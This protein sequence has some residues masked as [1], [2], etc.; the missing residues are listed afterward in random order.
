MTSLCDKFKPKKIT[1]IIG[2]KKQVNEIIKWLN[3]KNKKN[4]KEKALLIHGKPGI[5]KSSS[6]DVII[7]ELKL[8][9]IE[10]NASDKR[11]ASSID[12]L[13]PMVKCKP[14]FGMGKRVLVMDEV[15]GMSSG[16]RGGVAKLKSLI[17]ISKVPIICIANDLSGT[18]LTPIKSLSKKIEFFPPDPQ[19]ITNHVYRLVSQ[20]KGYEKLTKKKVERVV[21]SAMGDIRSIFNTIQLQLK[22]S[23]KDEIQDMSMADVV[24]HYVNDKEL[25]PE[26]RRSLFFTDCTL[27]PCYIHHMYP[28]FVTSLKDITNIADNLS[29]CDVMETEIRSN[30]NWQFINYV[31]SL[32][33]NAASKGDKYRGF[34]QFP[35]NLS[36][37]SKA[38]KYI[39]LLR[40]YNL[41]N[42]SLSLINEKFFKKLVD[43]TVTD[44]EIENC[45]FEKDDMYDMIEHFFG[46][47]VPTKMKRK[48]TSI[49][50]K[51][52]I[53]ITGVMKKGKSKKKIEV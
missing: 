13:F 7:R 25:S 52:D 19:V 34:I 27:M 11:S 41:D 30:Q 53:T 4:K 50:K 2:N 1:D 42:D 6:V 43:E 38:N 26:Q 20:E 40:K 3:S 18:K 33:S 46:K 51:R 10:T 8:D 22:T 17:E 5:G 9:K 12:D 44:W 14:M 23:D 47:K 36:K 39:K 15:D 28:N 35:S 16:D 48:I 32:V 24:K 45:K 37:M 21:M 31:E 29:Y 49:Y